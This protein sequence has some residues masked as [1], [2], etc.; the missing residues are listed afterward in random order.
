MKRSTFYLEIVECFMKCSSVSA[1]RSTFSSSSS[2]NCRFGLMPYRNESGH[3]DSTERLNRDGN[4]TVIAIDLL[5]HGA[6]LK[7]IVIDEVPPIE[8]HPR[9]P[10][11]LV[12]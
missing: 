8:V 6:E 2:V 1:K 5:R 10:P 9:L 4:A 12:S 11:E 7:V 3:S